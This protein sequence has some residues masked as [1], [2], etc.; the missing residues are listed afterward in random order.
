MTG[1]RIKC[2]KCGK[3]MDITGKALA[4]NKDCMIIIGGRKSSNTK[5]LY[6]ISLKVCDNTILIENVEELDVDRLKKYS[7]FGITAGAST[8]NDTIENIVKKIKSLNK[9][10]HVV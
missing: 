5:K 7:S 2:P 4:K 9:S 8:P 1:L 10:K 3:V 6:D